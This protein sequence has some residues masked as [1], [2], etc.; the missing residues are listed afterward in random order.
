MA[1]PF[2]ELKQ[3]LTVPVVAVSRA[4][5]TKTAEQLQDLTVASPDDDLSEWQGMEIYDSAGQHFRAR[6]AFRGWPESEAG[7]FICRGAGNAI[8]VAF[9][10]DEGTSVSVQT[11][12]ERL[13]ALA[14]GVTIPERATHRDLI[15]RAR[16]FVGAERKPHAP[17]IKPK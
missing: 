17:N 16:T 14:L 11:L 12:G 8:H 10:L 6:R 4:G 15:E 9:E 3:K 2:L 13:A 1:D 5:W 7:A